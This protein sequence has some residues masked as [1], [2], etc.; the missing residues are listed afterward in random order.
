[1]I[2]LHHLAFR[3]ADVASL[4]AFYR[5]MFGFEI[6]RD[7]RPRSLWLRLGAD[8]VLMIESRADGEEPLARGALEL[9]AF[10][11]DDPM[12]TEVRQKA[13][14]RNCYDGETEFTVYL[15]DPD[16]RR[17]GVSTYDLTSS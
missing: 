9:I 5:E 2:G 11:V 15:R 8:A 17:I 13:L 10:R 3:T 7:M 1:M 12:R 4:A 16:G 14:E 6:V